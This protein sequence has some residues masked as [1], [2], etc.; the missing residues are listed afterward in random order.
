MTQFPQAF[1]ATR[2][3]RLRQAPWI[4]S[5]AGENVLTPSDLIWAVFVHEGE[6]RIPVG[7]LP[8]IDRLSVK[9]AAKAAV[10]ARDLGIPAIALFPYI[11]PDGK[12]EKLI[13][14]LKQGECVQ[15]LLDAGLSRVP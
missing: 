8:G 7:S 2:M 4:R 14:I 5:L 10:R 12:D 13:G 11:G 3:R 15:L 6:D 9:D 1:P